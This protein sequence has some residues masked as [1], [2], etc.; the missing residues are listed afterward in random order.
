MNHREI[1]FDEFDEAKKILKQGFKNNHINKYELCV[2]AKYWKYLKNNVKDIKQNLIEFC[3]RNSTEFNIII[4]N[5]LIKEVLRYT[6]KYDLKMKSPVI[7]TESEL[8]YIKQCPEKYGKIL[9]AM[10]ILAKNSKK[11]SVIKKKYEGLDNG[12]Y[13]FYSFRE[14]ARSIKTSFTNEELKHAKYFL[15]GHSGFI[16]ATEKS[17]KIWRVCVVDENSDPAIVVDD[18]KHMIN[19]F[20]V[21]CSKC[22]KRMSIFE[23]SKKHNLCQ[24]C[25]KEQR[26]E[27]I[28]QKVRDFR[29]I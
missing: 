11:N 5:D 16:S 28:R 1:I 29:K 27:Y 19:F 9:F 15:D 8:K 25:Y 13:C 18:L 6:E 26:R 23:K 7:I 10:I 22:G 20:P 21:Y 2:L 24:D 12:Y 4:Y 3:E 14:I 17:S